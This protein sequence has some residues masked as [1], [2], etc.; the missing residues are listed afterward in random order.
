MSVAI[1]CLQDVLSRCRCGGIGSDDARG[2]SHQQQRPAVRAEPRLR[3]QSQHLRRGE[4]GGGAHLQPLRTTHRHLHA[5]GVRL[6]PV[7]GHV[8]RTE[9]GR[10]RRWAHCGWTA[11]RFSIEHLFLCIAESRTL[12]VMHR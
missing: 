3:G 4:G 11:A 1:A 9:C 5:Q 6:C 8:G 12:D 10:R 2:Q 7:H